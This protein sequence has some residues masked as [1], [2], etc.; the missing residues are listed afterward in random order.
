MLRNEATRRSKCS[1]PKGIF[2]SRTSCADISVSKAAPLTG[3]C[4]VTFLEYALDIGDETGLCAACR[5]RIME[6]FGPGRPREESRASQLCPGILDFHLVRDG[7]DFLHFN[8]EIPNGTRAIP[9]NV[10][11]WPEADRC[12][13]S[14]LERSVFRWNRLGFPNRCEFDSTYGLDREASTD[15]WSLFAGLAGA[16]D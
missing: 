13:Q 3:A 15:G 5:L 16:G 7:Q 2:E 6:G 9:A 10:C 12:A 11:L 8:P 4:P 1:R 14:P